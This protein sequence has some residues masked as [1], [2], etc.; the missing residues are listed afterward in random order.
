MNWSLLLSSVCWCGAWNLRAAVPMARF[1]ERH[2]RMHADTS[3][4]KAK[5]EDWINFEPSPTPGSRISFPFGP[6]R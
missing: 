1:L 3:I 6:L 2:T 4:G 5:K